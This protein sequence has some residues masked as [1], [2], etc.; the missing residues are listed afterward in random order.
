MSLMDLRTNT[1]GSTTNNLANPS[2]P[3]CLAT[4][5]GSVHHLLTGAYD[6]ALRIWDIRLP[7]TALSKFEH[8]VSER[9]NTPRKGKILGVDWGRDLETCAREVGFRL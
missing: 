7:R 9:G 1:I 6:G 4:S 8:V 2:T 3:S 5:L